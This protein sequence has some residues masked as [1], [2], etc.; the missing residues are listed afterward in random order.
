MES[1][2]QNVADHLAKINDSLGELNKSQ[3]ESAKCLSRIES[4]LRILTGT[5][6]HKATPVGLPQLQKLLSDISKNY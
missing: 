2:L 4:L 1:E 6:D 5:Q 3:S